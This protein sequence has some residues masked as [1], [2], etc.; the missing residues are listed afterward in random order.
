MGATHLL[1]NAAGRRLLVLVPSVTTEQDDEIAKA[2]HALQPLAQ[3]Q[4]IGCLPRNEAQKATLKV[5]HLKVELPCRIDML[6]DRSVGSVAS[7][8]SMASMVDSP[9]RADRWE[10]AGRRADQSF[11]MSPSPLKTPVARRLMLPRTP[12]SLGV[13]TGGIGPERPSPTLWFRN[14]TF[15]ILIYAWRCQ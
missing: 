5:L 9:I 14:F 10:G 15:L 4:P 12:S 2:L 1:F 11:L 3:A 8:A 6:T 7:M 13:R